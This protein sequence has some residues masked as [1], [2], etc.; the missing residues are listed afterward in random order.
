MLFLTKTKKFG[1][2]TIMG[3]LLGIIMSLMGMGVWAV[4]TG[5]VFGFLAR[6]KNFVKI[7]ERA[8]FMPGCI[9]IMP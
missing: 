8:A 5:P 6:Y 9:V 7:R 1:M 4:L 3:T 2:V